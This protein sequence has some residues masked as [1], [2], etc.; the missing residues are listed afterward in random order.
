M[1]RVGTV[2]ALP[3]G[4]AGSLFNNEG[5]RKG[6]CRFSVRPLALLPF[7]CFALLARGPLFP[8][9]F[10]AAALHEL[11][12]VAAIYLCGGRVERFV[13]HP[14]G[15]EIVSGGRLMSYGQ[16][17]AV[18]LAGIFVN[19]LCALPLLWQGGPYLVHVF[20]AC[21]LGLA[22]FNLLPLKRLDGGEALKNFAGMLFSADSAGIFCK[23]F[24][25]LGA[26][27]LFFFLLF[28]I[29]FARLNPML[30]LLF[31]YLLWGIL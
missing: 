18:S 20:S 4:G 5:K 31:F 1:G 2:G 28:G 26:V 27:G 30:L 10:I 12:H 23:I 16:G 7:L 14:F 11:G 9:A 15:A 17:L 13:L 24:S 8:C 3:K 22:L 29:F 21:S 6:G 25:L 19:G